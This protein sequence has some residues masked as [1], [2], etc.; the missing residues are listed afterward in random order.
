MRVAD[1]VPGG[2]TRLLAEARLCIAF[3]CYRAIGRLAQALPKRAVA[4]AAA[5]LGT[6][7]VLLLRGR[8][9]LAARHLRRVLGVGVNRHR[10]SQAVHRAFRSYAL[11]WLETFRLPDQ[12]PDTLDAM[13][14]IGREQLETALAMGRGAIVASPHLGAWDSGGAWLARQGWRPVT[15]AEAVPSRRLFDWFVALRR[16]LGV[17]S[18]AAGPGAWPVL[19]CALREGRVVALVA[20]RDLGRRGVE[21]EFFGETT[22]LPTGPARLALRTGAPLL[23]AAVYQRPGERDR[24]VIRP[25]LTVRPGGD[26]RQEIA[27]ITTE[28]AQEFERLIRDAPEQ[29]HL[30]QPNWPSDLEAST[31]RGDP[32]R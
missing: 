14:V 16:S 5:V 9:R 1:L 24:V 28:L 25:P 7:G 27:R 19:E 2:L 20:D 31:G 23:A 21:V 8:R 12:L 15:V 10:L 30:M 6:A 18:V 29:W 13:E 32:R 26:A 22:T 4:P 17:D 3:G 11:Y